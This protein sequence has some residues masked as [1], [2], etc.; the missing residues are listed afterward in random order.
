MLLL[1]ELCAYVWVWIVR[2]VRLHPIH[3]DRQDRLEPLSRG[4]L[5]D[6][7]STMTH[8]HAST[9]TLLPSGVPIPIRSECANRLACCAVLTRREGACAQAHIRTQACIQGFWTDESDLPISVSGSNSSRRTCFKPLTHSW[10]SGV[11]DPHRQFSATLH[12]SFLFLL[13]GMDYRNMNGEYTARTLSAVTSPNAMR[14]HPKSTGQPSPSSVIEELQGRFYN[15]GRISREKR[16]VLRSTNPTAAD[17]S[18]SAFHRQNVVPQTSRATLASRP[19]HQS[20]LTLSSTISPS[21]AT[22]TSAFEAPIRPITTASTAKLGNAP[23]ER[24]DCRGG[25][26]LF[27]I[28]VWSSRKIPWYFAIVYLKPMLAINWTTSFVK[29]MRNMVHF[30][31][32]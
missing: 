18:V 22:A 5:E 4:C 14:S 29:S 32:K 30:F 15:T 17:L 8:S 7:T 20:E 16:P 11:C 3:V 9:R 23:P 12:T 21:S 10:L 24:Y 27:V 1:T 28:L 31:L 26:H 25:G 13:Q 6:H 19:H 2:F